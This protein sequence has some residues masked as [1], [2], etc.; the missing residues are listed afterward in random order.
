MTFLLKSWVILKPLKDQN[1]YTHRLRA[2][3]PLPH[4]EDEGLF[5]SSTALNHLWRAG[6]W[7]LFWFLLAL[8]DLLS[9]IRKSENMTFCFFNCST[10]LVIFFYF[11]YLVLLF[12]SL[13]LYICQQI[14]KSLSFLSNSPKLPTTCATKIMPLS[15][16]STLETGKNFQHSVVM[17]LANLLKYQVL[18]LLLS[19]TI[20]V[21]NS[22]L[23]NSN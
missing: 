8:L 10:S 19:Q 13:W 17:D 1:F 18:P 7:I 23:A 6:I 5:R 11:F 12:A 2:T 3:Q 16:W 20:L 21:L 22:L 15:I 14:L 9:L 4:G